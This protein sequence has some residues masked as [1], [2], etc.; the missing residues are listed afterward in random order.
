MS[1]SLATKFI[2]NDPQW[3]A[4]LQ[5][6]QEILLACDLTEQFKW[7]APCYTTNGKNVV[8]LASLKQCCVLGFFKGALLSDPDGI[9]SKPGENSRSARVI[10][11]SRLDQIQTQR[12]AITALVLQ[13]I[14]V[15]QAGQKVTVHKDDLPDF[16]KELQA[17]LEEDLALKAA[18][19]NL[20]P[21]RKR[22]YL[23]FISGAKQSKTRTKRVD[24][25]RQRIL[26]GKG[27]HDCVCGLSKKMP[28]C[29]GSH[30]SIG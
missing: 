6:L 25:Y 26:D 1:S 7:K 9:L 13:A 2:Q 15:E 10:R 5:A 16:P 17:K 14:Q 22:G 20:T 29:D 21:G 24:Q 8:N 11:F 28:R 12:S 30:K 18:F 4:E 23:L 27:I 19:D 3:R